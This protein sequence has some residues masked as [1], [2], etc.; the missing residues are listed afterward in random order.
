MN[1]SRALPSHLA[2]L[3]LLLAGGCVAPAGQGAHILLVGPDQA[4]ARPSDA[5]RA[6]QT[7]DIIRISPG[8]YT[9]CAVW[10]SDGLVI[11]ATGDGATITGAVCGDKGLFVVQGNNVTIRNLSFNGARATSHNGA[12]IRAEGAGLTVEQS[13]FL[14]DENGI[15]AGDN[16]P[17]AI[18][19]RNSLFRGNGN[20][21]AACAHGI[22]VGHIALLRIEN[23]RFEAQHVGHH[24][25]SRAARTEIVNNEIQDGPTGSASYLVDLP[26]GGS[27][28]ISGNQFEKGPLSQNKAAAIVI[29]AEQNKGLNPAGEITIQDNSLA[30]D[31]GAPTAFVQSYIDASVTLQNN[32]FSGAVTPLIHATLPR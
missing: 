21:I 14:D 10:K 16:V 5:A 2:L 25:K 31:T 17:S 18:V 26:N 19:I 4:Y 15:L 30:N 12:G 29:G 24:I 7:G 28:V 32:R 9:D 11:E 27:A 3:L 6:A 13:R 8:A 23:S 1:K 22:Y 20:C